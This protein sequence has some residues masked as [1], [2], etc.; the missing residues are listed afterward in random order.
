M[1]PRGNRIEEAAEEETAR[2]RRAVPAGRP[3]RRRVDVPDASAMVGGSPK[4][5]A[6]VR[7]NR[8]EAGEK[9][10]VASGLP[11]LSEPPPG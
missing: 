6:A 11:G 4:R 9:N 2:W 7:R 5:R 1:R 8:E 10:L 3:R